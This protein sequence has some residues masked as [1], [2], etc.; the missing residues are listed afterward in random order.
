MKK[1]F[2]RNTAL[3]ALVV[4]GVVGQLAANAATPFDMTEVQ[5]MSSHSSELL[6]AKCG[7]GA[8]GS[9]K[10]EKEEKGEHK[11][12]SKGEHKCG[13]KGEHKCGSKGE[14]KCGSKG[15][16]KCGSKHEEKKEEK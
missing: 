9:K 2:V 6:A 5:S 10:E 14:H 12:G 8:C 7:A 4:T 11:C 13:S 3:S 1:N 15:E 16:H